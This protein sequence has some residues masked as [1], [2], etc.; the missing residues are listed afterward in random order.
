LK[1]LIKFVITCSFSMTVLLANCQDVFHCKFTNTVGLSW[2]NQNWNPRVFQND[3]KGFEI[4]INNGTIDIKSITNQF[5]GWGNV[6]TSCVHIAS[7]DKLLDHHRCTYI[8]RFS[9]LLVFN[10]YSMTGA[11][12]SVDGALIPNDFKTKDDVGLQIF[13]CAK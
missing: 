10:Q 5:D 13:N 9:K 3:A 11:I 1:R 7:Q 8:E 12:A 4:S 6:N 2:V